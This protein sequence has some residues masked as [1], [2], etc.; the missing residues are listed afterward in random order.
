MAMSA[1][2]LD[3]MFEIRD[4]RNAGITFREIGE[5]FGIS[6]CRANIIYKRAVRNDTKEAIDREFPGLGWL[7]AYGLYLEGI[8]TRA[9]LEALSD[10]VILFLLN[11]QYFGSADR[12]RT[13]LL[14][15]VRIFLGREADNDGTDK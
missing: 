12:Q 4:C 10:D 15:K 7:P 11:R 14:K 2:N 5:R 9:E 8:R 3:R 13:D 1:E 6:A